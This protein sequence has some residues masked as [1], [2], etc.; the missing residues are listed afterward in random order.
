MRNFIS[1]R[2]LR[3]KEVPDNL[4]STRCQNKIDAILDD[5]DGYKVSDEYN[6][7]DV[8][9]LLKKYFGNKCVYCESIPI[10][11]ST[12]RIDHYRPKKGIKDESEIGYYWLAY[13]W[14]NLIQSCQLCNGVKSNYFPLSKNSIRVTDKTIGALDPANRK[15]TSAPLNKEDRLLLHPELDDVETHFIF[16]AD[17][18]I[19][20]KTNEGKISIKCY[21]LMREDLILWR[22]KLNDDLVRDI[23]NSLEIYETDLK[24]DTT[25]AKRH[26]FR[27]LRH[28]FNKLLYSFDK[29]TEYSLFC[30]FVF[31]RFKEFIIPFIKIPDYQNL[32]LEGYELYKRDPSQL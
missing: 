15:P 16:N 19:E 20:G 21:G 10:A 6:H 32:I 1:T 3:Y 25:I 17:G 5:P 12:F 27:F 13:E 23:K 30:F 31:D 9:T 11:S 2:D 7:N 28:K 4:E 18:T 14:S 24:I 22:K 26:F 8:R 29:K